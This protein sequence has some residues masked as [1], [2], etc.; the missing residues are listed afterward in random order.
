MSQTKKGDV[1][2]LLLKNLI[3][4]TLIIFPTIVTAQSAVSKAATAIRE[5]N[6]RNIETQEANIRNI[7]RAQSKEY[8]RAE[9]RDQDGVCG[10]VMLDTKSAFQ[11]F[12]VGRGVVYFESQSGLSAQE[13]AQIWDR[14]CK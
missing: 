10:E 5:A 13:F 2:S 3:V 8:S 14:L 4:L 7:V 9:F 12:I 1:M 11:K 6:Q